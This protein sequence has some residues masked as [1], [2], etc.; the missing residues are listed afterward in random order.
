MLRTP[1]CQSLGVELP[2]WN[3]GMGGGGAG[4]DLAAAVSTA[5]GFGVLGMGGMPA[6][7]IRI[8]IQ[9]TRQLTAK[10]FGVNLLLPFLEDDQIDTC[11]EEGVAALVLFWGDATPY[12]RA[13]HVAGVKAVPQVGSVDEAKAAADAGADAVMIQGVEA[14]GHVKGTTSLSIVL[15]AVVDAVAPLPVVAAGGLADG[16]GVAAAL[17]LGAQAVSMGTRFVCSAEASLAC[18]YKERVVPRKGLSYQD[19]SPTTLCPDSEGRKRPPD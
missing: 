17:M 2:I 16:R 5:G 19:Q 18:A 3:A 14:G 8:A 12:I 1:L 7:L 4:A 6:P 13:A 9:R 10:P 15:P 11:L